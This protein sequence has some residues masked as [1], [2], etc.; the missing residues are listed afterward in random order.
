M[1]RPNKTHT[2]TFSRI[3][4]RT[5]KCIHQIKKEGTKIKERAIQTKMR[6]FILCT[7]PVCIAVC[8]SVLQCVAVCCSVLQ[9]VAVCCSVLQC[10][11]KCLAV[12][13][14]VK[15]A[16]ISSMHSSNPKIVL[17]HTPTVSTPPPPPPPPPPHPTTPPPLPL[18]PPAYSYPHPCIK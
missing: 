6:V 2:H 11:V 10:L 4:T 5:R 1:Y 12:C 7:H 14:A 9:C 3:H 8:C 18:S 16:R 15:D 17:L 13:V